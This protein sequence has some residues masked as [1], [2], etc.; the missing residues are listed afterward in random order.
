MISCALPLREKCQNTELF[1]VRY[2]GLIHENTD[3]KFLGNKLAPHFSQ[4][5]PMISFFLKLRFC[6]ILK[7]RFLFLFDTEIQVFPSNA[8]FEFIC[9]ESETGPQGPQRVENLIF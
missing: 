7:L 1:L 6:F 5:D 9:F 4:N 3:Q 8:R 2:S